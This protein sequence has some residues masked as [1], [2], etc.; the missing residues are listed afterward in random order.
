MLLAAES[1]GESS[2]EQLQSIEVTPEWA[3][4]PQ[5]RVG[6]EV[7]M[8]VLLAKQKGLSI[9]MKLILLAYLLGTAFSMPVPLN[10]S[11]SSSG[12]MND[13]IPQIVP[14]MPPMPPFPFFPQ[15]PQLP[16]IPIPIPIPYDPAQGLP[17]PGGFPFSPFGGIPF[18]GK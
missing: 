4:N 17:F 6:E 11:G 3:S 2:L 16:Q 1:N 15:P 13:I 14:Q 18:P 7:A 9:N 10:D 12:Q 8:E 5:N